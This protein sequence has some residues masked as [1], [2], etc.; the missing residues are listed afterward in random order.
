MII[1]EIVEEMS[2]SYTYRALNEIDKE[3]VEKNQD[4]VAKDSESKISLLSFSKKGSNLKSKYISTSNLIGVVANKYSL[5]PKE[6]E[7]GKLKRNLRT[8]IV[9]IYVE[10]LKAHKSVIHDCSSKEARSK[11]K[12]VKESKGWEFSEA[13]S[14][15]FIEKRIP[16]EGYKVI[17][18]MIV[19]ILDA[20]EQDALEQDAYKAKASN[21]RFESMF[22]MLAINNMIIQ[23]DGEN[24]QKIISKMFN[25]EKEEKNKF[26][27]IEKYFIKSYY[28]DKKNMQ[29]IA[30]E[31]KECITTQKYNIDNEELALDVVTSIKAEIVKKILRNEDFQKLLLNQKKEIIKKIDFN[32]LENKDKFQVFGKLF[33]ENA[34]GVIYNIYE[35][36]ENCLQGGVGKGEL[37]I[38]ANLF[39]DKQ[40]ALEIQEYIQNDT[41]SKTMEQRKKELW[42][43]FINNLDI[44]N[45]KNNEINSVLEKYY[46]IPEGK[47][48]TTSA[49]QRDKQNVF[50]GRDHI[51][52]GPVKIKEGPLQVWNGEKNEEILYHGSSTPTFK[53]DGWTKPVR[54]SRSYEVIID[55]RK[56]F[57]S[58]KDLAQEAVK[59]V[60]QE[61]VRRA[62][63]EKYQ[64]GNLKDEQGKI[65]DED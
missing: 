7:T 37:A 50:I 57:V 64:I 60:T 29:T 10:Y 44:K 43:L 31:L 61:D 39:G 36:L 28:E 62:D 53:K 55:E 3:N 30:S 34:K 38:F 2:L 51:S 58:M 6:S 33:Q 11:D 54:D 22:D 27:T 48:N 47:A 20:F 49:K 56:L 35:N 14:E 63:E 19:D 18:P 15:V 12:D 9:L 52:Y 17:P 32:S 45:I 24:F 8:G 26:N 4:I 42:D 23:D 65:P 21:T 13:D 25:N 16:K 5:G 1:D 40:K 41:S 46:L 59:E